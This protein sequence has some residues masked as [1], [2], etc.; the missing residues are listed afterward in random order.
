VRTHLQVIRS[1]LGD[2]EFT[3]A[4][5]LQGRDLEPFQYFRLQLDTPRYRGFLP[6]W[7]AAVVLDAQHPRSIGEL[8]AVCGAARKLIDDDQHSLTQIPLLILSDDPRVKLQDALPNHSK[9]VF[10]VDHSSLPAVRPVELSLTTSPLVRVVRNQLTRPNFSALMFSPYLRNRP[11][12]GWRFFGRKKE[13]EVL[14]ES[15]ESFFVVG[16]RRMGKTSLLRELQR[17]MLENGTHVIFVDVEACQD[18]DQVVRKILESISPQDA[19]SAV[20]RQIALSGPVIASVLRKVTSRGERV[21]LILDELGNVIA[22]QPKEQWKLLGTLREYAHAGKL[23]IIVSCFQELFQKQ[24]IDRSGPLVN[25]GSV[26]RLHALAPMEVD[27]MVAAPLLH[28]ARISNTKALL[29]LVLSSVGRHPYVLQ[30]FC[31]E[32]FHRFLK[33]PERDVLIVAKALIDSDSEYTNC[34]REA[35]EEIFNRALTPILR[36]LYLLRCRE[37]DLAGAAL[38]DATMDDDWL[39]QALEKMGYFSSMDDRSYLLQELEMRGMIDQKDDR[40]STFIIVSPMVYY[41]HKKAGVN[42]D[43]FFEKFRREIKVEHERW[44]LKAL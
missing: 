38:S 8:D 40:R 20:R 6:T 36:Y 37:G 1:I 29:Q 43:M 15:D 41:Y 22:R 32:L 4:Q 12:S 3:N 25:F 7:D 28:W 27:E 44:G 21:V 13:L 23:R 24:A 10:L 16:G 9:R 17:R 26:L 2:V 34:F 39:E 5:H 35:V 42:F 30:T 19:A 14:E 11:A 33:Q 31:Q 18:E